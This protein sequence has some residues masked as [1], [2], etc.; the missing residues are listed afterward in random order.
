MTAAFSS[1]H[2]F[3]LSFSVSPFKYAVKLS[4]LLLCELPGSVTFLSSGF[5]PAYLLP[6][7]SNIHVKMTVSFIPFDRDSR[8]A[9]AENGVSCI[10]GIIIRIISGFLYDPFAVM[11]F[12]ISVKNKG[13]APASFVYE[14]TSTG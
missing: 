8:S 13:N 2:G 6:E 5:V 10:F 1:D 7:S 4:F 9:A 12:F 3:F 11:A 14:L